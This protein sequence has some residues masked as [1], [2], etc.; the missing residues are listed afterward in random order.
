[1][2]ESQYGLAVVYLLIFILILLVCRYFYPLNLASYLVYGVRKAQY[3]HSG[4]R[5]I[6][7]TKLRRVGRSG[8]D[9][10]SVPS[11]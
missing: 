8:Q 2:F 6:S 10:Q 3:E 5:G 4:E 11:L 7:E 1:M 9:S